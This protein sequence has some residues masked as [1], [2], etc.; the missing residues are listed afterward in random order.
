[1]SVDTQGNDLEAEEAF[2]VK[3]GMLNM[4]ICAPKFWDQTQ[5]QEFIDMKASSGDLSSGWNS[6]TSANW[7]VQSD[8][9]NED[10]QLKSPGHC[11]EDC[12]RQHWNCHC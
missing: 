8:P 3:M 10:D 11:A 7:L 4:W 12:N 5:V 2:I 9:D 6:G 1:M